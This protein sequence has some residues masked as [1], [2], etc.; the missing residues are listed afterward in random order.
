MRAV[1]H[2]VVDIQGPPRAGF[3]GKVCVDRR[4][5]RRVVREH[6]G[7]AI[8]TG[9][10]GGAFQFGPIGKTASGGH[11]QAVRL[12]RSR[13]QCAGVQLGFSFPRNEQPRSMRQ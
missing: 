5:L 2:L 9:R 6:P 7:T 10:C 3:L 1:D 4:D 11:Q 13:S 8:G 12:R